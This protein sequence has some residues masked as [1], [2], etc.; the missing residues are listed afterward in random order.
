MDTGGRAGLRG[1]GES[2]TQG[3][4]EK[5]GN[6]CVYL[7][8]ISCIFAAVCFKRYDEDM[9]GIPWLGGADIWTLIGRRTSLWFMI[10]TGGL[11]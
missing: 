1:Q 11:L 2:T 7:V 4:R 8:V 9:G 6:V 3:T 5:E 10:L